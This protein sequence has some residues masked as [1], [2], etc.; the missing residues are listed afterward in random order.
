M[1]KK[2][3]TPKKLQ[4]KGTTIGGPPTQV[5][6]V[7]ARVLSDK[8]IQMTQNCKHLTSIT[9]SGYSTRDAPPSTADADDHQ[10]GRSQ[11]DRKDLRSW[12]GQ[13]E[14]SVQPPSFS[15]GQEPLP[16]AEVSVSLQSA[17][18]KVQYDVSGAVGQESEPVVLQVK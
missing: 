16:E 3:V 6:G 2:F 5:N 8:Q 13:Q 18:E 7:Y 4:I 10:E 14:E 15:A 17:H 1:A 12:P 11:P 9:C